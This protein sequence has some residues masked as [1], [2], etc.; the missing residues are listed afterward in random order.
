M[1]GDHKGRPYIPQKQP[2]V[3]LGEVQKGGIPPSAPFG[4]GP[5]REKGLAPPEE[6]RFWEKTLAH[7]WAAM[8]ATQRTN[9]VPSAG[10]LKAEKLARTVPS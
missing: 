1:V 6:G 10:V 2:L 9:C 3:R 5:F 7:R 8:R 4:P